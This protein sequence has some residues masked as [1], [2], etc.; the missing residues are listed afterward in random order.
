MGGRERLAYAQH[1]GRGHMDSD[2]LTLGKQTK[3]NRFFYTNNQLESI[4]EENIPFPTPSRKV[5]FLGIKLYGSPLRVTNG[6]KWG[7]RSLVLG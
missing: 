5:D 6:N 7:E 3:T 4:M 1:P 2:S